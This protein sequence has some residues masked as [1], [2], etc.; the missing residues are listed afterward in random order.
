MMEA[1][2]PHK[3]IYEHQN[4]MAG[5][6]YKVRKFNNPL[7]VST[8]N[9]VLDNETFIDRGTENQRHFEEIDLDPYLTNGYGFVRFD[10]STR[11][12]SF[13]YWSDEEIIKTEDKNNIY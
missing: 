13:D 8:R 4:I 11:F 6:Y 2:F 1:Q 10:A 5:S 9:L 3:I 12:K 7:N